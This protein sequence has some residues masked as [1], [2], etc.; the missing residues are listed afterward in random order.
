[1]TAPT[2]APAMTHPPDAPAP[3]TTLRSRDVRASGWA[4]VNNGP[5]P[6]LLSAALVAILIFVFNSFDSRLN[7]F[8]DRLNN[9]EN[10]VDFRFNTQ[11]AR[12]D[13]VEA[14]LNAKIDK[15]AVE[16]NA[17]ID[18]L[19]VEM[20]AKFAAMDAKFDEL[21]QKVDNLALQL[22]AL[23]AALNKTDEVDAALAG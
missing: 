11:E 4:A 16:M 12:L 14:N 5:I 9:F 20:D 8:N 17:R 1:M 21:D 18:E 2:P 13:R 23:I 22:T 6:A 10:R 15:L 7:A 3:E 19:A